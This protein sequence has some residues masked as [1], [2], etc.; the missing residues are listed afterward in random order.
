MD[1][2]RSIF[3]SLISV[4]NS[5]SCATTTADGCRS[6]NKYRVYVTIIPHKT[7]YIS[8]YDITPVA[9]RGIVSVVTLSSS[10]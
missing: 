7:K 5:V 9:E 2:F 4:R 3:F 6:R 10:S 8:M 1:V